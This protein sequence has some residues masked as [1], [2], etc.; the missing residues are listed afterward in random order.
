MNFLHPPVRQSQELRRAAFLAMNQK[1]VL[2]ATVGNAQYYQICGAYFA[3]DTP[4][5]SD[6]GSR[7]WSRP[8]AWPRPRRRSPPRALDGIARRDHDP[9]RRA[10]AE[11]GPA[12]GR[13]A[14]VA[15]GGLQRRRAGDG[16]A[17][18]E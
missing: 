4:L 7:R 8:A 9:R 14:A 1:D 12:D 6:V 17:D 10:D 13:G 11:K 15:R 3:C 2:D 5:A 18:R 16:L